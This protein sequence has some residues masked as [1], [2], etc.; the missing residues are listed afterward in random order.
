MSDRALERMTQRLRELRQERKTLAARLDVID[1]EIARIQAAMQVLR[2]FDPFGSAI[3][4]QS[5]SRYVHLD[6]RSTTLAQACAAILRETGEPATAR[7]LLKVLL[8][9]G[10]W[11]VERNHHIISVHQVLNRHPELFSKQ[12]GAWRLTNKLL[13]AAPAFRDGRGPQPGSAVAGQTTEE[14]GGGEA[15]GAI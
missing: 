12:A 14:G 6:L 8:Q 3:D 4:D 10:R 13:P 9:E 5:P 2:E 15:D 7:E 1:A 11:P